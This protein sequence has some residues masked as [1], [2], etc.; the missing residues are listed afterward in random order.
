MDYFKRTWSS[1]FAASLVWDLPPWSIITFRWLENNDW[2]T[3]SLDDKRRRRV[4]FIVDRQ[5]TANNTQ[6][7]WR[8]LMVRH[9]LCFCGREG[10]G[11]ERLAVFYKVFHSHTN[12]CQ[13]SN[14]RFNCFEGQ[15]IL[16]LALQELGWFCGK[17]IVLVCNSL[18]AIEAHE[19]QLFEKLLWGLVSSTIFV[20]C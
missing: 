3:T 10:G 11:L 4:L 14:K 6:R 15:T 7:C 13:K 8:L 5:P 2:E 17:T 19:R 20:R 12:Y 16:K 1:S 18:P 9:R